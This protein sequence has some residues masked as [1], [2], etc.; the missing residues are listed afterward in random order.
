MGSYNDSALHCYDIVS[1]FDNGDRSSSGVLV[2]LT[3]ESI[4]ALQ[5]FCEEITISEIEDKYNKPLPWIGIYISIASL[6][7]VLAMVVDLFNGFR[8]RKFWFPCKVFS[9]NAVSITV[10]AVA[11][12]LPVD[13]NSP[14]PGFLD[15][16]AKQGSLVFMC[17]MMANLMPSL[18][19][20][21][22]KS[23]L[24]N[25]IG[26]AILIITIIVNIYMEINTGVIVPAGIGISTALDR[27]TF[28]DVGYIYVA[29]L[30]FLLILLISSAI[31]APLSKQ[32]LE[33]KYQAISK[34]ILYNHCPQD[35]FD[36][37]KLRQH[38]KRYWIMAETGSPQFVMVSSPL[39]CASGIICVIA[40][41]IYTHL[42]VSISVVP[43]QLRSL[44]DY[45]WSMVATFIIQSIG[46][47]GVIAPICRS[48]MVVSFKSFSG[49]SRNHL[50][51]F[52][53][54]KYWTQKLCEW[55][56]SRITFL[57]DCHRVKS[58]L[59]NF[60]NLILSTL[61]G[62]QKAVV[63]ACKIIGLIPVVVL[64]ILM[65]CSYYFKSLKEMMLSPP[66]RSDYI[67]EDLRKCVLL[68]EDN[69]ELAERTLKRISNS[70]NRLIQKAEK[71]QDNNLLK[72]LD[73]STGFQGVEKFE[74]Y[75]VQPLLSIELPNSW[76]LPIVTLTCIAA[77]LPNIG[78][79]ATNWLIKCVGEGLFY[80]CVVEESLNNGC[81]YVNIQK[82]AMTSWDEVEDNH[83]WLGKTLEKNAY[84]G[85]TS[86]EIL[87]WFAHKAEEI[88][89]EFSKSLNG[90]EPVE[91]LPRKLIVA[92]SMHRIAHSIMLTYQSN[93]LEITEEQLFTLLSHMIADILVA[94][95]TN[96]PRV[97]VMK[98]HE[99]AIE[100]R[101]ASVEAATKLLGRTTE[102]IKRI[103]MYEL[104]NIDHDKMAFI[105]EWRL[106]LQRIP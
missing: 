106:H 66:S 33:L 55:K 84:K 22:N 89:I 3:E 58:L 14:M 90:E 31:T 42:L 38:V 7:C 85:K 99:S 81:Q 76:S 48:F 64:L 1:S 15:Q 93:I 49:W 73:K 4:S 96:M 11:M 104:P 100:K 40:V 10:I 28:M 57:S 59:R 61:I 65:Y 36:I 27:Y 77:A 56:E 29:L 88:V 47:V 83:K 98:C 12:K 79:D 68:L 91:Y 20:M 87:E 17:M 86:R 44:S 74:I 94:C 13:L 21:D 50:E 53:V 23:L 34:T 54:E 92:N 62:F 75:Q 78:K 60:K 70:M 43:I 37:E 25:V 95:F 71:E 105:D 46:V 9:L 35:T 39:S 19:S 103:K 52:K 41:A 102:I 63:V 82:A 18:A 32:I 26:L 67:D 30:L 6:F 16:A 24:A 69:M 101:E 97:I 8:K 2:N 45:K 51:V 80:T 72:F 5:Y